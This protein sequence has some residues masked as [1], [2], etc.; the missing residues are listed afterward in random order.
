MITIDEDYFRYCEARLAAS[1]VTKFTVI[2]IKQMLYLDGDKYLG[3]VTHPDRVYISFAIEDKTTGAN[4]E[5]R[6]TYFLPKSPAAR[7]GTTSSEKLGHDAKAAQFSQ[8]V[9]GDLKCIAD[10]LVRKL[11]AG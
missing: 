11:K 1:G 2:T 5:I 4:R 8:Q 7:Q 6:I 3:Y 10:E 9:V